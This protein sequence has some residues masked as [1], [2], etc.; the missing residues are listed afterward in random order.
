MISEVAGDSDRVIGS[1]MA[2]VAVGPTP[3]STPI[4]VPSSTPTK[5]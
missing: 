4:T 5:Q 1:S 2:M 3:G